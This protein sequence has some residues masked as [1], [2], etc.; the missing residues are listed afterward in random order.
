M[1]ERL[2]AAFGG[3][4]RNLQIPRRNRE[5]PA[6]LSFAQQRLWFIHQLE[7]SSAAYNVPTALRL[8]GPLDLSALRQTLA[9][10]V[11][12]HEI[13][14]TTFP[15]Q[16]GTPRQEV[17]SISPLPLPVV[18]LEDA[19]PRDREGTLRRLIQ[20]EGNR[21]FDLARAPALRCTVYRLNPQEHVLLLVMHH[22]ISDGWSMSVFFKEFE[23]FYSALSQGKAIRLPELPIQYSDYA[24][25][26]HES[27]SGE[28]LRKHLDFW[29][30]A[31]AGA[32]P[33]IQ[34][35]AQPR[36]LAPN[37]PQG[38][39]RSITLSKTF[40]DQITALSQEHGATLFIILYAALNILLS[41]WTRQRDLVV[42]TVVAGRT[43]RETENLIGCFMNFLPLRLRVLETQ[44]GLD[45]LEAAKPVVFD[46]Y[47]HQDCPFDKIVEAINP[48]RKVRQN[49]L[50]NVG[51]LL[52]NFP[53]GTLQSQTLQATF[54]PADTQ[55]ALLDLRFVAEESPNGI[56]LMCE[57][58]RRLFD[59]E[60]VDSLLKG[61]ELTLDNFLKEP[62]SPIGNY[63][64]LPSLQKTAPTEGAEAK[65]Q[66]LAIGGTFTTEPLAESIEFLKR[67]LNFPITLQFTPYNQIFQ[68]LLDANSLFLR[69][70]RGLNVLLIRLE[71]WAKADS[72]AP[73]SQA[74][75]EKL[76]R[77]VRDFIVALKSAAGRTTT[78]FLVLLCPSSPEFASRECGVIFRLEN[79][80]R[81][82]LSVL[83]GVFL[84]TSSEL[85]S[86]YLLKEVFDRQAD[87]LGHVPY[88]P[89]YFCALSALILR[90][91]DAMKR[92]PRKVIAVDCDQ[93]LWSGVCGEDGPRGIR[94]DSPR[95]LLQKFLKDQ[96]DSGMLLCICSKNNEEDVAEVFQCQS[97]MPLRPADFAARRI[98]WA[99][100]SENLKALARELNVGLDSFIFIDDNPMEC[101]EV[102]ANCPHA[103]VLQLPENPEEIG[104]FLT[105][106]W[107]LDHL[108]LTTEDKQRSLLYQQNRAREQFQ[109]ESMSFADFI[110]GLNLEINISDLGADQIP[111]LSQLTQRTNQFNF[112]T[113]RRTESE[114][115]HLWKS[116]QAKLL[117]ISVRDRFGDYGT[118]GLVIYAEAKKSLQIDTFLLSCRVLGKGVEH[119]ILSHIGQLA[120]ATGKQ[121]LEISIVPTPKNK[122]ARQFME[123]VGSPF[124]QFSNGAV[125]FRLPSEYARDVTFNP[126]SETISVPATDSKPA[127]TGSPAVSQN[128]PGLKSSGYNWVASHARDPAVILQLLQA[129]KKHA[130]PA[131]IYVAPRN[132]TEQQ[133]AR[134]WQDL[135]HLD[136]IGIRDDF[137]A[138]GGTSLLA[139]RLFSQIEKELGRS[140]PLVTLFQAPTI[141]QLATIIRRKKAP[142]GSSPVVPIQPRG[143][144]PPLFLIHG[145]GGGLLWGYANLAANLP[146]DQPVYGLEPRRSGVPQQR[147][148]EELARRYWE[149]IRPIQPHGPYYL[150]G[151]C[152]GG[153]VAYEMARI[154]QSENEPVAL[155]ALIDSPAPNGSYDQ[156]RWWDPKFLPRFLL[157]STYWMKDFFKLNAAER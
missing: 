91:F 124:R 29:K 74:L 114:L 43:R 92:P 134:I 141:E 77:A 129:Q 75:S 99:P 143:N 44:S 85:A 31:L 96:A 139:V 142:Q 70:E 140:M 130:Q 100:K 95:V 66:T 152:F 60:T 146:G 53:S 11:A 22:I 56:V 108:K 36:A 34:L 37:E 110:G 19:S 128:Y 87:Q 63:P 98:N 45:L 81:D 104:P 62:K 122:P 57:F 148:V 17:L 135:L 30:G 51:F 5:H 3:P 156:V 86:N 117:S 145:A 111:R 52:Q 65:L 42:G 50:Y 13:L 2:R 106:Y 113:R 24:A 133:L 23:L 47:T 123:S 68:Q 21:P 59:A 72:T 89:E 7:P 73:N 147:S 18:S 83:N 119:R 105:H 131:Q 49:P 150:G 26:Q 48:S 38:D 35:P 58:D 154:A 55:T 109:A 121:W 71:D 28:A 46:A 61:F 79:L 54:I 4:A 69:N 157:N 67:E 33:A 6:P 93:T 151:Y 153:F 136:R 82:D 94:M 97:E 101:A 126:E 102:E 27:L 20:A 155:L 12:R 127:D 64:L 112:T 132:E 10:I 1:E 115:E 116:G 14:R 8:I 149:A 25:W 88:T 40:S 76:E 15:A 118:V 78:P 138:L 39:S 80:I 107:P 84:V 144:K 137:F 32:P 41:K 120:Q 103:L 9:E 125:H 16:N 90:R